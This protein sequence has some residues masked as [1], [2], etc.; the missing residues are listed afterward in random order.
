MR[1]RSDKFTL[2]IQLGNA[3]MRLTQHVAAALRAVAKRIDE[4]HIEG[5]VRDVNGNTVGQW[6]FEVTRKATPARLD[7]DRTA[8]PLAADAHTPHAPMPNFAAGY[9]AATPT[10][11]WWWGADGRT[12]EG[13][14]EYLVSLLDNNGLSLVTDPTGKEYQI[15]VT[16]QLT[17][18]LVEVKP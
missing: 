17:P 10:T 14:A 12:E 7:A 9:A 1:I 6:A 2:T 4:E 13:V 3:E 18:V 16:V 11:P 15:N 5:T 8:T